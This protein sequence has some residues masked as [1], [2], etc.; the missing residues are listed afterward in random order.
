[1]SIFVR[2]LVIF[3]ILLLPI[4]SFSAEI[5]ASFKV[6]VN[7]KVIDKIAEEFEI[8]DRSDGFYTVYVLQQKINKFKSLAPGAVILEQDINAKLHSPSQLLRSGYH[9]YQQIKDMTYDLEKSYPGLAKVIKYGKSNK[10]RELLALKISDN[11]A[12]DEAEPKVLLTAATHGDEL[13]TVEVLMELTKQIL[14]GYK[15]DL[16]FTDMVNTKELYIIF[17]INPDGFARRSRYAS[18]IDP[19]RQYPWPGKS[20]HVSTLSCVTSIIKFYE[21]IKFSGSIDFHAHGK[22]IMYPW[23]YTRG[24]VE[25]HDSVEFQNLTKDMAKSNGYRYGQISKIIYVA[26]GSSADYYYWKTKSLALG[27]ELTTSKYP[28]KSRIPSIVKETSEM[29]WKFIKHF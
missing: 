27:I 29:T 23:A 19:N 21:K 8:V 11:V 14:A 18:G 9:S 12:T 28:S 17:N 2:N 22:L 10:G 15:S 1:M 4:H 20:G 24:K 3:L 6:P 7:N 13:I 5:I 16:K 26:K 25:S